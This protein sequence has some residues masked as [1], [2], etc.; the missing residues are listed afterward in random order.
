MAGQAALRK[1]ENRADFRLSINGVDIPGD[2][3][4]S[5]DADITG[6][7]RPRLISV[8]L[9]EKRGGEADEIEIVLDDADGKLTLPRK[10]QAIWLQLGWAAGADVQVGLV[11]KGSFTVDEVEW[12]MAP[13]QVRITGRSADLT[14]GFRV[15]REQGYLGTTLGAIARQV[16]ARN[17]YTA[18]IAPALD[19][20]AVPVLEQHQVSDMA[21]LRRL[22]REHDAVATVKNRK[23]ILSPIGHG[24][25]SGGSALP[26]ITLTRT[27]GSGATYREVDRTAEAGVEARYHDADSATR[28][29]VTA[30]GT[31]GGVKHRHRIRRVFHSKTDAQAAADAANRRAQRA[32]AEFSVTL[33]LGRPDIYPEQAVHLSGFKPP[34][35]ARRWLVA[36]IIHSLDPSGFASELKLE[37]SA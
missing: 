34:A 19:G 33:A 11:D 1:R 5:A 20:I 21:L 18:R 27:A 23:L 31:T 2:L 9:T 26:A 28:K 16:A 6:K 25:T 14:A 15:R 22:G 36:E 12:S 17:G 7:V 24:K 37:A 35:D 8:R 10:G 30:G 13:D 4:A 3:D 32:A 29:T